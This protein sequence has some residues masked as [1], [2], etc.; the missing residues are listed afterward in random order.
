MPFVPDP[1]AAKGR[2]ITEQPQ[3]TFAVISSHRCTQPAYNGKAPPS[4]MSTLT[5]MKARMRALA[6]ASKLPEPNNSSEFPESTTHPHPD[7]EGIPHTAPLKTRIGD[8]LAAIGACSD[9]GWN[10]TEDPIPAIPIPAKTRND[11]PTTPS[12][13]QHNLIDRT[14]ERYAAAKA[15]NSGLPS[16]D[17]EELAKVCDDIVKRAKQPE[18]GFSL[19]GTYV[20]R[21]VP[22]GRVTR[23][24]ETG[25]L[26]DETGT[27]EEKS[28][29]NK[30]SGL[31]S[32]TTLGVE[33]PGTQSEEGDSLAAEQ[34]ASVAKVS[35]KSVRGRVWGLWKMTRQG[36]AGAC[37]GA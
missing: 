8:R 7:S 4:A 11:S 12:D 15:F 26:E 22:K 29:K 18:I 2:N 31:E 20:Q 35:T 36:T 17:T 13:V 23:F 37:G 30:K 9:R 16:P 6:A 10:D 3:P 19:D 32:A 27:D 25:L 28:L 14:T 21:G 1:Q 5:R 24:V 34:A 33:T